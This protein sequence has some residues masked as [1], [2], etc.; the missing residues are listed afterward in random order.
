MFFLF[1]F[2]IA[3]HAL[4]NFGS[5]YPVW[6][7]LSILN[8]GS[9]ILKGCKITISSFLFYLPLISLL[10]FFINSNQS[11]FGHIFAY[12]IIFIF[13]ITSFVQY[14]FTKCRDQKDF[15][16]KFNN[17]LSIIC[18]T[19]FITSLIDYILLLNNINYADYIP[20]DLNGPIMSA[21]DSR[22]RAF[23]NEPTDLCLATNSFFS[24]NLG[25]SICL[26]QLLKKN[27]DV[28]SFSNL[29][30]ILKW[31]TILILSRSAAAI[32]ALTISLVVI[33][34]YKVIF[35]K[36][37][38]LIK[39][40]VVTNFSLSS[41]A[42]IFFLFIFGESLVNT[43]GGVFTKLSFNQ[44][45]IS[46]ADRLSGWIYLLSKVNSANLVEFL[47][48]YGPGYISLSSQLYDT[49]AGLSW[50][51]SLLVDLGFL[52]FSSFIFI[53]FKLITYLKYMPN[54]IIPYYFISLTTTIIHLCTQTGFYLP[55]LS[56]VLS[57]PIIFY[58][59]KNNK[60]MYINTP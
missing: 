1:P 58:K 60:K 6:L 8:F 21:F 40:R 15:L 22:A 9:L 18:N 28:Q 45:A 35:G 32:G 16:I 44:D 7:F 13:V 43:L 3:S 34:L 59:F 41:I 30:I 20:A 50:I 26:S 14:F 57:V 17:F 53:I 37:S 38:F 10:S 54:S 56:F 47:F 2:F 33:F 46:V 36:K 11:K 25:T 55:S 51:L 39:K 12:W 29:Y 5:I 24:L 27:N 52:G 49:E 4:L 31:V 19:L 23:W 48:G 42:F